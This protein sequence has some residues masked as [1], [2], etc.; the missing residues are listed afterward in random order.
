MI[1]RNALPQLAHETGAEADQAQGS[2]WRIAFVILA[3]AFVGSQ[4]LDFATAQGLSSIEPKGYFAE[5]NPLLAQI[6]DPV[7]RACVGFALKVVLVVFVVWV[8]RAQRRRA[9]GPALLL[10]GTMAGL[11]GAWSNWNPWWSGV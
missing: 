10:L 8:A 2:G 9:V 7:I 4:V 6:P 5:T 1:P 11:F 3:I